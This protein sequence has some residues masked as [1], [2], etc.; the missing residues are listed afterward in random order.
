[1]LICTVSTNGITQPS[2][3][4]DGL[5]FTMKRAPQDPAQ[6]F[7]GEYKQITDHCRWPDPSLL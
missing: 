3:M 4:A 7:P 2:P 6:I 1:M 5:N